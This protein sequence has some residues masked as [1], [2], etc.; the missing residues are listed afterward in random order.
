M[1]W[2]S[3]LI[4]SVFNGVAKLIV[5]AQNLGELGVSGVWAFF[6]LILIAYIFIK[7][8][9]E[10][11]MSEIAWD[12]RIKEV[13]ADTLMSSAVENGFDKMTNELREMRHALGQNGDNNV[14]VDKK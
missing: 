10:R 6:S 4:E 1:D 5:S 8:R 12:V 3:K 2:L 13:E 14:Q 9:Q 11:K 7:L